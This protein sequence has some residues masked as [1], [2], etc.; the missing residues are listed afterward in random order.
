VK[1]VSGVNIGTIA[2]GKAAEWLHLLWAA[3]EAEEYVN[4]IYTIP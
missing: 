4:L 3:S 2:V 1:L